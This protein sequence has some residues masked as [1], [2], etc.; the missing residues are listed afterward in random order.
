MCS[1]FQETDRS[2]HFALELSLAEIRAFFKEDRGNYNT[3]GVL[4]LKVVPLFLIF[5]WNLAWHF[6]QSCWRQMREFEWTS[7]FQKEIEVGTILSWNKVLGFSCNFF[8]FL[9][10]KSQKACNAAES[11]I[12]WKKKENTSRRKG[13]ISLKCLLPPYREQQGSVWSGTETN[14]PI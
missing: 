13:H 9:P 2:T 10:G 6:Y 4:F 3:L 1:E 5:N 14:S 12:L 7:V 8:F 11:K